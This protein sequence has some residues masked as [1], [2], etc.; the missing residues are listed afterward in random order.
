MAL[1]EPN[2]YSKSLREEGEDSEVVLPGKSVPKGS[3][4]G[5]LRLCLDL[6]YDLG[7]SLYLLP[8]ASVSTFGVLFNGFVAQQSC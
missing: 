3:G 6:L 7:K 1:G 5:S 4:A 2:V 8:R